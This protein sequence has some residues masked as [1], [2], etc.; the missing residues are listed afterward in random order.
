MR[1]LLFM[2]CLVFLPGFVL[3]ADSQIAPSPDEPKVTIHKAEDKTIYEY[4]INGFVYAIK[5]VPKNAPP[6][7]LVKANGN[8]DFMRT[9]QPG[10]M[11]IP[12]WKIITW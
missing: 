10:D 3:A 5:V 6:Y 9:D 8:G 2:L 7:Y 11:L 12:S 1:T 4:S